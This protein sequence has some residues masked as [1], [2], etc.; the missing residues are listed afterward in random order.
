[1]NISALETNVTYTEYY[2][3]QIKEGESVAF[4]DKMSKINEKSEVELNLEYYHS[5]CK[6]FPGATFRLDDIQTAL[7][8]NGYTLETL[9]YNG[10]F[11]QV[12]SNF[13]AIGQCSIQIDIA[14]IE[15]MRTDPKYETSAKWKI[16]DS[17]ARFG[18]YQT[19]VPEEPYTVVCLEDD[20]GRLQRS[21][22]HSSSRFPTEEETKEMIREYQAKTP[23]LDTDKMTDDLIDSYLK[24]IEESEQKR[25]DLMEKMQ[26]K[27]EIQKIDETDTWFNE[28]AANEYTRNFTYE[29][30]NPFSLDNLGIMMA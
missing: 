20:N 27:E 24:M 28:H 25:K 26:D 19:E 7:K 16:G 22:W 4:P 8:M 15:K 23:R 29:G 12:G 10:S 18:E 3:N 17:I 1:M 5:L 14:V 9:G 2:S 6:E 11:H 30:N 13:G 21:R